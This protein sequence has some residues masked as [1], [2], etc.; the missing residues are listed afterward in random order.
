MK[1]HLDRKINHHRVLLSILIILIAVGTGAI[2]EIL[3]FGAVVFFRA[4]QQ[5]EDYTNNALDLLF[6]LIG[7]VIACFFVMNH[8]KRIS[9]NMIK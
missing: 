2:N 7:A 5:V 6:N 1:P 4:T 8:H 9:E 3:E